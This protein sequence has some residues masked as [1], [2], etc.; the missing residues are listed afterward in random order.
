MEEMKL[1]LLFR[2][3]VGLDADDEVSDPTTFTKYVIG[4]CKPTWPRSSW[5]ESWRK[6]VLKV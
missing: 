3:F 2:W 1:N 5:R 4:Y 6:R